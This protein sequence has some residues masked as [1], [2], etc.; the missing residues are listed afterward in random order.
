M[1]KFA[2]SIFCAACLLAAFRQPFPPS[3]VAQSPL[4]K[5]SEYGFF[6]GN[7]AL[8][9]P[10]AGIVPYQ[11]NTPLFSDYAEKLRFVRLP[12]GASVPYN[13][14]QVLAFPVGT[15]IIKTFY[16][17]FDARKPQKGRRLMETRLLIH[18]ATAWKALTYIWNDAQTEASLEVAG[19]TKPVSWVDAAGKKRDLNYVVPNV[20]Q[21]KGCHNANE[22]LQPIG[23]SARQLNGDLGYASGKE[24]QLAYWQNHGMLTGVPAL[25]DVPKTA[26]WNDPATGSLDARARAWLDINC[27]HCHR[28]TGPAQTS[29]LLLDWRE[30]NPTKSGIFKTPVAAGK[31]TGGLQYSIVPHKPEASI[32]LY[33][34]NNIDPGEMMPEL[35]RSVVH[36]EGVALI[37]EWIKNM[38][39][40]ATPP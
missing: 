31:G 17:P 30:T 10:Q 1:T 26:V 24:N 28:A 15:V 39:E 14:E 19:D 33:R 34:I 16:Y 35:G 21:C 32:L 36:E 25:A 22:V 4:E 2:T 11:L 8:Q 29:G 20:N 3:E 9:L 12:Q 40:A 27:A 23:P 5:L 38:P 7:I 13:A 37:R 6:T 18:E